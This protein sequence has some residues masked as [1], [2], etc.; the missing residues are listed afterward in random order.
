MMKTLFLSFRSILPAVLVAIVA[1]PVLAIDGNEMFADPEREARAR[2][3][4]RQLRC[5]VCQ[6]QSI[7]DSNAG[8]A[9]DLRVLV[10]TRMEAGDTDQE[11]L[12]YISDRYGDYVLLKPRWSMRNA[13][14]WLGPPLA[15]ILGLAGAFLYLRG[16]RP[17]AE[18]TQLSEADRI[19]ARKILQGDGS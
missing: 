4:G 1:F 5:M 7:F 6:N 9:K 16:R 3:I 17:A 11:V 19:E 8:L 13:V 14:L 10:R 18:G 15:L 2:D 12:T